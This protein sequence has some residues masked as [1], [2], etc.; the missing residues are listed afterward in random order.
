MWR[1]AG[2]FDGLTVESYEAA[3]MLLSESVLPKVEL[4]LA[5]NP[6]NPKNPKNLVGTA[7]AATP[8]N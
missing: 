8:W 6:K 2:Q 1:S 5:A 3:G 4:M 7:I